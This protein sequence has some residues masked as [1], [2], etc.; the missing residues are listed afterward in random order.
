MA[1]PPAPLCWLAP[2]RP[3]VREPSRGMLMRVDH[4]LLNTSDVTAGKILAPQ[5]PNEGDCLASK[6]EFA[7][8]PVKK[9]LF[10]EV[11]QRAEIM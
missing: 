11:G 8:T 2:S 5:G 9:G 4:W 3:K 1:L 7:E 6:V 10:R